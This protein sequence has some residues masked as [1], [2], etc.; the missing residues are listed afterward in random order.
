MKIKR[1][2]IGWAL[3]DFA[4]SPFPSL[5]ITAFYPLYFKQVMASGRSDGDLL[6]GSSISLSMALVFIFS[7]LGGALADI[8]GRRKLFMQILT[9]VC[10]AATAALE[11][12]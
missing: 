4:N 2:A 11:R 10:V 5:M 9:W 3:Y 12:I 7:P 8:S 6:W 1:A